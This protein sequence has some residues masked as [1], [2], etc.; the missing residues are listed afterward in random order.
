M[1][2]GQTAKENL[3]IMYYML[4]WNV[5]TRL[6]RRSLNPFTF[7][8]FFLRLHSTYIYYNFGPCGVINME[9]F[10]LFFIVET[11]YRTEY[12]FVLL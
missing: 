5:D 10:T 1:K 9:L 7:S 8:S 4:M 11:N 3:F 12:F 6:Y 2:R